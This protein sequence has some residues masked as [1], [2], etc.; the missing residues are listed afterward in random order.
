MGPLA[1]PDGHDAPRLIDELVPCRTAMVD[2]I[3]VRF[4]TRFESQ[5]S[6]RNCQ[7]FSTGLSSGHYVGWHDEALRHV[8]ASLITQEHGVCAAALFQS[9]KLDAVHEAFGQSRGAKTPGA[10]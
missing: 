8:P 6:R 7:A 3:V 1:Q 5:L 2:E 4:E 10:L 9:T